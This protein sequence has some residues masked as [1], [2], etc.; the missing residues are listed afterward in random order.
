MG[1]S[2][3]KDSIDAEETYPDSKSDYT[4]D[5][6]QAAMMVSDKSKKRKR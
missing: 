4:P 5:Y 2:V 3:K 6:Y 1:V